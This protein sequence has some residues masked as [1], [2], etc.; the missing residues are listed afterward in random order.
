MI[1]GSYVIYQSEKAMMDFCK[2]C[3]L[4]PMKLTNIHYISNETAAANLELAILYN[5]VDN[6]DRKS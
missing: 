5:K 1:P 2:A 4:A 6:W 3:E